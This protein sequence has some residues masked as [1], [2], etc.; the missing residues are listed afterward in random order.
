MQKII[1]PGRGVWLPVPVVAAGQVVQQVVIREFAEVVVVREPVG[2]VPVV[3]YF[4][5]VVAPVVPG[6]ESGV[7]GGFLSIH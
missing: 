3:E 5:V 2:V 7:R 1:V 4:A 6:M